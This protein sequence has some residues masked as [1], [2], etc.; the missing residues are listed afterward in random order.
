MNAS[1]KISALCVLGFYLAAGMA[2]GELWVKVGLF[3]L[4]GLLTITIIGPSGKE[5]T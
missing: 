3:V 1:T 4:A 5:T 2:V